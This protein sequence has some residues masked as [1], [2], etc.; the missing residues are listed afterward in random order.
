M[1]NQEFKALQRKYQVLP[2]FGICCKEQRELKVANFCTC[3]RSFCSVKQ[4]TNH[5][6]IQ[7]SI[8]ESIDQS[9]ITS[10]NQWIKLLIGEHVKQASYLNNTDCI[11]DDV[12]LDDRNANFEILWNLL[13][14]TRINHSVQIWFW[15]NIA[16]QWS[17][18]QEINLDQNRY[19]ICLLGIYET[20]Q[21]ARGYIFQSIRNTFMRGIK[22]RSWIPKEDLQKSSKSGEVSSIFLC[23][24]KWTLW[25]LYFSSFEGNLIRYQGTQGHKDGLKI[26]W[27][28]GVN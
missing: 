25:P 15:W 26:L 13:C 23:L 6:K 20:R 1:I 14:E 24:N 2:N 22:S 8:N 16:K 7:F 12:R 4:S 3:V 9:K 21:A 5:L 18:L 19:E 27:S 17:F 10:T 28:N 11:E